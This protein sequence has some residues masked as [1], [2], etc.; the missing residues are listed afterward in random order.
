M[1]TL[2]SP[3]LTLAEQFASLED[4]RVERTKLHALL[5]IVSIA[6]CASPILS[7]ISSRAGPGADTGWRG[8]PRRSR[9]PR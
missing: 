7:G 9:W 4:P 6:V 2:A 3:R 8:R 1:G 5:S